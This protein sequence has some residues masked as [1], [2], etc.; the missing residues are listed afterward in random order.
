[1]CIRGGALC[2]KKLSDASFFKLFPLEI[3]GDLWYYG[4]AVALQV[5][6]REM[7]ATIYSGRYGV[8]ARK[9]R[10][11]KM[12]KLTDAVSVLRL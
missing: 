4:V 1:V 7:Q 11:S 8:A 9:G 3:S 10:V 5:A 6:H 2:I 12:E